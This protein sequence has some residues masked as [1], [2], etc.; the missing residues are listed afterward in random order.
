MSTTPDSLRA[1]S[2][3]LGRLLLI[4]NT[5]DLGSVPEGAPQPDLRDVIPQAA[6]VAASSLTHWV[7]ENAKTTRAFLKRVDAVQPLSSPLQQLDIQVLPRPAKGGQGLPPQS[8]KVWQGLLA[9]ALAGHDVGLI[10]EAGLPGVADPGADLVLAAH[11]AGVTVLPMSGPSSLILAVAAS[12]LNG[13]SFAFVGYLPTDAAQRTQRIKA[14]EMVSSKQRQTQLVI[15]TPYRNAALWSAL[16]EN[17]SPETWLSASC[18]LT[19]DGGWCQTLRVK[20]WRNKP[21]KFPDNTPAVFSWL[22]A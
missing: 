9:P 2:P 11:A 16:V 13:Q 18:G 12:G 10:S 3:G 21:V 4:P 22:A 20:Q 15:E 19:L 8:D 5:L 6:I 7:A 17:L 1:P 14:L